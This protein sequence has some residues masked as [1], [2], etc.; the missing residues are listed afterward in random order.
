MAAE[1]LMLLVSMH[2]LGPQME[3]PPSRGMQGEQHHTH[4]G[5]D[6]AAR[7]GARKDEEIAAHMLPL[8]VSELPGQSLFLGPMC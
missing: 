2:P 8:L 1:G 7:L 6:P 3:A 5:W 4:Q